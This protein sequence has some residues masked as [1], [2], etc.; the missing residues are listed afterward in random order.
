MVMM[1]LF[2]VYV[3]F[4]RA[5]FSVFRL[6]IFFGKECLKRIKPNQII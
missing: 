6:K 5:G 4:Q 2:K 3:E 1:M